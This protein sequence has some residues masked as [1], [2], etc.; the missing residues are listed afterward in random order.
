MPVSEPPGEAHMVAYQEPAIAA[1]GISLH[2]GFER[3]QLF[4]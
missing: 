2:G 1:A 3:M 4:W